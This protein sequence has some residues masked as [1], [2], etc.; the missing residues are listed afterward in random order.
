M[1]SLLPCTVNSGIDGAIASPRRTNRAP[2]DATYTATSSSSNPL[3]KPMRTVYPARRRPAPAL[4]PHPRRP[5]TPHPHSA[6]R[7]RLAHRFAAASEPGGG[8]RKQAAGVPDPAEARLIRPSFGGVRR[9]RQEG[10]GQPTAVAI[11]AAYY[12]RQ[13]QSR[14]L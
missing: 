11:A 3:S 1:A 6:G 14:S 2:N 5:P 7:S 10:W 9:R 4:H 8:V 13:E 12:R